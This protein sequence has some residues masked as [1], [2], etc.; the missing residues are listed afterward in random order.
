MGDRRRCVRVSYWDRCLST[1]GS[2]HEMADAGLDA[3]RWVTQKHVVNHP[4]RTLYF[5]PNFSTLSSFEIRTRNL[6]HSRTP[7]QGAGGTSSPSGSPFEKTSN[8]LA[9][10]C[11]VVSHCRLAVEVFHQ[12]RHRYRLGRPLGEVD[13]HDTHVRPRGRPHTVVYASVYAAA[14][15]L[16]APA[17]S[18]SLPLGGSVSNIPIKTCRTL[19]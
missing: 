8:Q 6:R 9:M 13:G 3:R 14:R 1:L 12:R 5:I 18:F 19:L 11:A 7:E 10:R 17:R 2:R 16:Q 15:D 4:F